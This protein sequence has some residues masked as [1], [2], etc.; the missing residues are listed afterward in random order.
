[1]TEPRQWSMWAGEALRQGE[2]TYVHASENRRF[3]QMYGTS[4]VR[5]LVTETADGR[6]WAWLPLRNRHT[7][8]P[9]ADAYPVFVYERESLLA[10]CFPYGYANEERLGRGRMVRLYIEPH[11]ES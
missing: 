2:P 4:P 8:E 7:D 5:V 6:Y 9:V 11:P 3:P 10:M 1:M